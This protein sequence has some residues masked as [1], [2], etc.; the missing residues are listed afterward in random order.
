MK[1]V[2]REKIKKSLLETVLGEEV[3]V[4]AVSPRDEKYV[5]AAVDIFKRKY[6]PGLDPKDFAERIS[7]G[8]YRKYSEKL[9]VSASEIYEAMVDQLSKDPQYAEMFS[10]QSEEDELSIPDIESEESASTQDV[11]TPAQPADEEMTANPDGT[12]PENRELFDAIQAKDP[13]A[14]YLLN[15]QT[16]VKEFYEYWMRKYLTKNRPGQFVDFEDLS[17]E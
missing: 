2:N 9:S 12:W 17:P 11:V 10:E 4:E 14:I 15:N 6:K 8:L 16:G 7:I 1:H 5:T 13:R 3:I